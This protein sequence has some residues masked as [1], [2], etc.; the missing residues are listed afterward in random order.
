MLAKLCTKLNAT[1]SDNKIKS[2]AFLYF[3]AELELRK[4]FENYILFHYISEYIDE[5][6]AIIFCAF[7][8]DWKI[9]YAG[10]V[11]S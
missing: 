11:N 1:G 2:H 8:G 10:F 3:W 9:E 7:N 5:S 4:N 6:K